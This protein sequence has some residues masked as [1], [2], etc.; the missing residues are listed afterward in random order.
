M[1]DFWTRRRAAALAEE[2][3]VMAK[4]EQARREAEEVALAERSDDE[5][6]CELELPRPEAVDSAELLQRFMRSALPRRLKQQA[7]RQFWAR[8]PVLACLDGLVDYADDYTD[9]ATCV[10]DLQTSYQV[11]KGL[12]AHIEATAREVEEPA[13]EVADANADSE[14]DDENHDEAYPVHTVE[15]IGDHGD[16]EGDALAMPSTSRRMSFRFEEQA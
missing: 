14:P 6:L 7:L 8:K 5:L 12:L 4:A 2:R 13:G 3:A 15:P 11:G 9:A 1:S 16:D 10:P